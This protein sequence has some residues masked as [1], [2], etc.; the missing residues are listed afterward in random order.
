MQEAPYYKT[1]IEIKNEMFWDNLVMSFARH[2]DLK[3]P[4]FIEKE[5]ELLDKI[6]APNPTSAE[7]DLRIVKEER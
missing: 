6:F 2:H 3:T 1:E 4:G 5:L 7:I